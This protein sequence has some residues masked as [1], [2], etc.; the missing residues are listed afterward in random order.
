MVKQKRLSSLWFK[1]PSSS[2]QKLFHLYLKCKSLNTSFHTPEWNSLKFKNLHF[3][4]P[5]GVAGGLDK[6][7]QF[8]PAWW[9]LGAGFVEVGTLTPYPEPPHPG[10]ILDRNIS[11]HALWNHMGFPNKGA[12]FALKQ[13]QKN[14]PPVNSR[15]PLFINVGKSKTTSN[16]KA[17]EDYQKAMSILEIV[18]DAFVVNISSPNSPQLRELFEPE[19]LKDFLSNLRSLTKKPLILKMSPDLDKSHFIQVLETALACKWNGFNFTNTTMVREAGSPFPSFGGVSGK[20][21]ALKSKQKLIEATEILA[22][23]KDVLIIST[24]GI[25]SASDV[26]ERLDLGAHLVQV[27]SAL[28]FY[29]PNFFKS[30]AK[31]F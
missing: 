8:L 10:K 14:L 6:N 24:G 15:P 28:V 1:L 25:M 23:Q 29:G 17:F 30:I 11:S 21:L 22:G 27:Y 19:Y 9:N 4:N 26:K 18:T 20:P 2:L 16:A 12:R 13:I 31:S 5:L 3:K 7:A